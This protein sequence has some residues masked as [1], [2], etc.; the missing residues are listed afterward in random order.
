MFLL[1]FS[2]FIF[3]VSSYTLSSVYVCMV[4]SDLHYK[5]ASANSLLNDL[6]YKRIVR[7][8]GMAFGRRIPYARVK[9]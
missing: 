4:V 2:L 1:L 7:V 9:C 8:F 3:I 6:P 5:V